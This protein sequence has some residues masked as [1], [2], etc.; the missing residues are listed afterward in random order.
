MARVI[1]VSEAQ[2][3]ISTDKT[4][5]A[6]DNT[7]EVTV[8]IAAMQDANFTSGPSVGEPK[9]ISRLAAS[10]VQIAVTPSTGVTITQPT[11]TLDENGVTTAKFKSSNAATVSVTATVLGR[12]V[13]GNATVIVGGGTPP[14]PP[15]GDPFFTDT[16]AGGVRTN[17]NGF[18]WS[19][20]TPRVAV[21]LAPDSSGDYA[22]RF[23]YGPDAT[24]ADSSAEQR[25]A[26]GRDLTQLWIEWSVW[27]PSNY[28]H[29]SE[30][31][32]NNKFLRIWG[33]NYGA[34][35]KVGCSMYRN[36]LT[37]PSIIQ[38]EAVNKAWGPGVGVGVIS[39]GESPVFGDVLGEW[40]QYRAQMKLVTAA[41]ADN[42]VWRLWQ[43]GV[44]VMESTTLPTK[45]DPTYPYWNAGY[46][47]G[48]SNSGFTDETD[49][50]IRGGANGP[51]FYD[52][53]P[54]W[55]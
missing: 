4:V 52:T 27:V 18:T 33:N 10:N 40:I 15:P 53:D 7:E 42:G 34:G 23:R 31:P 48:W 20:N 35:N 51:K 25:F 29:R 36:T 9:P 32:G 5:V 39:T 30:S 26:L 12:A 45:Y 17:S 14:P 38:F 44:K 49:F 19:T 28:A 55:T 43:N 21:V 8:Y 37:P 22:L 6:A 16:F 24:G 46:F 41:N 2:C 47:F 1:T 3:Q 13:S 50:Y 54:G 11:G